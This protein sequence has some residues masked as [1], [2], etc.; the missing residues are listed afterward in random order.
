MKDKY[1]LM[2]HCTA[3]VQERHVISWLLSPLLLPNIVHGIARTMHACIWMIHG[4]YG[5]VA[6]TQPLVNCAC[7]SDGLCKTLHY[8]LPMVQSVSANLVMP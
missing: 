5:R 8:P 6:S 3:Y 1:Q 7:I 4:W 2:C